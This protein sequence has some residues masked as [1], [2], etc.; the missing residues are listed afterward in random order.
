MGKKWYIIHTFSGQEN[1][2]V[3]QIKKKV[4][5]HG[6]ADKVG[7]I[8]VPTE[9]VMEIKRG[10]RKVI[11][12]TFFPGY[13]LVNMEYSP[14]L[15]HI[16]RRTNGVTGFI[17]SGNK[18]IPTSEEEVRRIKDEMEKHRAKPQPKIVLQEGEN[19]KIVEGAF[20]NFTG[21]I[22]KLEPE[23]GRVTVMVSIFGRSTPVELE[24]WQVEKV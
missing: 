16:I 4:E 12:R 1:K 3:E 23:K 7:E 11:T 8:F 14:K 6:F 22:E 5:S 21:Y 24:Y 10:T 17:S 9:D 2:V 13:I 19:V 20:I 15:W 18:P